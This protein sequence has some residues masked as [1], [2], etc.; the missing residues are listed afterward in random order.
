MFVFGVLLVAIIA[1]FLLIIALSAVMYNRVIKKRNKTED[2]E[3]ALFGLYR[4]KY[5]SMHPLVELLRENI[6]PKD[7][8]FAE[9]VHI[10]QLISSAESLI[11]KENA[12]IT[13]SKVIERLFKKLQQLDSPDIHLRLE[14]AK[15]ELLEIEGKIDT[16]KEGYNK[17]VSAYNSTI[18]SFPFMVIASI[19]NFTKKPLSNNKVS[20]LI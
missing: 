4:R 14:K 3:T 7:P 2:E 11:L 20:L 8:I 17:A 1:F 12:D 5:E 10:K 18:S 13:A 19:F 16:E 6:D 9:I 15:N